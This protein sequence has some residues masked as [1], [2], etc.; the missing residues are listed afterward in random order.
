MSDTSLTRKYLVDGRIKTY[1]PILHTSNIDIPDLNIHARQSLKY[2]NDARRHS[3]DEALS[4]HIITDKLNT[5]MYILFESQIHGFY[6]KPDYI[7]RLGHKIGHTLHIMVSV[8]RAVR[9]NSEFNQHEADRLVKKKIC[10]L[11]ICA[12]NL[13]CYVDDVCVTE[14]RPVLHILSPSNNHSQMCLKAWKRLAGSMNIL[15][16]KVVITTVKHIYL[17]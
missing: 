6:G 3:N 13:E 7:I 11:L 10:G 14:V 5:H 8:T 1:Q 9:K 12:Q 16:I 2:E 4:V 17:L 15:H